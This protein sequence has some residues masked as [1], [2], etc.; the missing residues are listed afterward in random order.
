MRTKLFL[1]SF[2][3]SMPIHAEVQGGIAQIP[4][5]ITQP[6]PPQV[7][8]QNKRVAVIH[9]SNGWTAV[10]GIALDAVAGLHAIEIK[11]D[12][13]QINKTFTVHAKKYPS[14]KIT[15]QDKRKVE[16]LA[17]DLAIIAAQYAETISTYNTWRDQPLAAI[18][19][20]VPVQGRFSSPFG[21]TRIFNNIPKSPHSG[22]DIAAPK[23]TPVHAAKN[24]VVTKIGNYFYSGNIVFVDHGQ[25]FITSY[26][27]LDSVMVK[28]GQ[29]VQTGDIIGTVGNTGRATGPH[30]HWSVSLNN[31]RVD[32]KL[33]IDE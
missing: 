12:Q 16:P 20:M 8:Y 26:A 11:L 30:L 29:T 17:E 25:S 5:E 13:Q 31:V 15:I 19:L 9:G 27:H 21:Y 22:L 4:L 10:V 23:G 18:K 33:F 1:L 3:C 2:L 14:E 24:G 6:T 32:P 7:Y 28:E